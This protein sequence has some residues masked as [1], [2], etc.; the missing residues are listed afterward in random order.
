[1][2]VA[3]NDTTCCPSCGGPGKPIL[4]IP[5]IFNGH[6][7]SLHACDSCELIYTY[8]LP[9]DGLLRDIYSGEYWTRE[10]TTQKQGTIGGLVNWFNEIRLAATVKPLLQRLPSGAS[11]LEVGCGS[12]QLA[13]YLKRKGYGVEVTDISR[14]ILEEIRE[15]SG[16]FGYC[17]SLEEISFPHQYNGI[18]FNNVL[19]HLPNPLSSLKKANHLLTPQGLIFVE[20]PNI[21][22]LQFRL[23]CES[24]YHLAIPAH[25]F[26]FSPRSLQK[27]AREA[28]LDITW[29]ST[30]SIRTSAAGYVASIFPALQPTRLRQHWSKFRLLSYLFL[31]MSFLPL[32]FGEAMA[33]KG[34]VIRALCRRKPQ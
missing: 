27:L 15:S 31:Q 3:I 18:I 17:G 10:K 26:H 12:G 11:I 7:F 2:N 22:G 25:L 19:E 14:E 28:S 23:L 32:A 20:V 16:I 29:H 24:W 33:G 6:R 8:P 1:M 5:E 13:K 30:F 21:A 4:D 34:A 9:S